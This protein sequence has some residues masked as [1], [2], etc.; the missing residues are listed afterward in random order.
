LMVERE[1]CDAGTVTKLREALAQG[2]TQYRTLRDA[3]EVLKKKVESNPPND[4]KWH[5]KLGVALFFLG[6]TQEAAEHLRQAEGALAAFY[7]G[8]ALVSLHQYD[9]SLRAFDKQEMSGSAAKQ[10]QLQRAGVY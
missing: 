1:D 6:H 2:G 8:R 9:E 5:L 3:T 7:L 10:A 4:K